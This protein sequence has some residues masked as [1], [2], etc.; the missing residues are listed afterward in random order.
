MHFSRFFPLP[1]AIATFPLPP[2]SLPTHPAN[3]N[4]KVQLN[5]NGVRG[6]A[7]G[8]IMVGAL[9]QTSSDQHLGPCLWGAR[10]VH[11]N[12]TEGQLINQSVVCVWRVESLRLLP[13][14]V[15]RL[16]GG[17]EAKKPRPEFGRWRHMSRATRTEQV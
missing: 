7:V 9:L 15:C 13:P 11:L 2:I 14:S 8:G 16:G 1:H 17:G 5:S 4:I 3:I 10:P 6:G 12:H